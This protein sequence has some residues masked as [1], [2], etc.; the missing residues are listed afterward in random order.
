MSAIIPPSRPKRRGAHAPARPAIGVQIHFDAFD[1]KLEFLN[2]RRLRLTFLRGPADGFM[3]EVDYFL[4]PIGAD[5][6]QQ[7][8]H[9]RRQRGVGHWFL[10]GGPGGRKGAPILNDDAVLWLRCIKW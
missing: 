2:E 1:A 5:G 3:D 10:H 8:A 6:A 4:T 7:L 9:A